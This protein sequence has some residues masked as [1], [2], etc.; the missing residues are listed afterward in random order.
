MGD[1]DGVRDLDLRPVG[2]LGGDDVLGD[3]AR[4][5]GGRAVDLGRVLAGERAAAVARH[6]AVGVDDD[7]APGE[8]GVADRAADHEPAGRVDEEVLAQLGR[9]VELLGQDRLNDV[10]PEV[11]RDHRF[12]A[13]AVLRGDQELLDLDR[14]AVDV[15]HADLGL[16][17]GAQVVER[18]GL[19]HRGEPLGEAVRQRDRQRHQRVRLVAGVAEHHPLVTRAGHVELVVVG[20]VGARLVGDV[21]ALGDVRRLLVDRVQDRAGVGREAEVPVGVADLADRLARHLLD[22]DVGF[23][24]DLAGDDDQAGVDERLAGHAT[25]RF[26]LQHGVEHAVGDLVGD[27]VGMALGHRLGGEQ[28]LVV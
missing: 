25:V 13:L 3:P 5:I 24:R 20:G 27:L 14:P 23:R 19:S 16:A 18:A 28:E 17:V 6:A 4:R 10:L 21:H 11:V 22:V 12:G 2:K 9:V 15:A 1:T 7:L 26:V 8:A